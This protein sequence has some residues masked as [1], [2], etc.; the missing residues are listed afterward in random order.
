MTPI[1]LNSTKNFKL[2]VVILSFLIYFD[3]K[4]RIKKNDDGR[5]NAEIMPNG[6]TLNPGL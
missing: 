3:R 2:F 5:G 4:Y 6:E 1:I